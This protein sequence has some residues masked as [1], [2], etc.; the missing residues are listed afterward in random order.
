[1]SGLKL[2]SLRVQNFRAFKDLE[3]SSLGRVNLIV[4]KNNIG[5]TTLLEALYL[6]A[7]GGRSGITNHILESRD[8]EGF[9]KG[10][11]VNRSDF[12]VKIPTQRH[13]IHGRPSLRS[14]SENDEDLN[15]I[16]KVKISSTPDRNEDLVFRLELM[17]NTNEID[18]RP[19]VGDKGWASPTVFGEKV[20]SVFVSAHDETTSDIA[21]M[22]DQIELTELEEYVHDA[23]RIIAPELESVRLKLIRSDETLNDDMVR[24]HTRRVPVAK[25]KSGN[26]PEPLKSLG[27]GMNRLFSLSLALTKSKGGLLL[28][29]EIEN[30]LHHSIQRKMWKLIFKMASKLNVQVFA[31]THSLDCVKAFDSVA[32]ES[33]NELGMLI[34]LRRRRNDPDSIVAVTANEDELKSAL[35]T[36]IDPR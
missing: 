17:S 12:G 1:M 2:Q 9:D 15:G 29:D 13:L 11:G 18:W 4:G 36:G 34:Q 8:L 5:K 14:V 10:R 3:V 7:H 16:A 21:Q 25:L 30:G 28:I 6:Y 31:T 24:I 20:T 26:E 23:L 35:H 32:E 27:A 33:R 19:S 22:W